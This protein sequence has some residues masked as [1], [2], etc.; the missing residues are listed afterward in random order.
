ME[1]RKGIPRC[2]VTA[3]MAG[4]TKARQAGH[5]GKGNGEE[6]FLMEVEDPF[7]AER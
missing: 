2:G 6:V 5:L 1:G 7:F 3:N 4:D